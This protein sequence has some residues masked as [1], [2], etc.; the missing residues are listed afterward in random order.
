M[1]LCNYIKLLLQCDSK[2]SANQRKPAHFSPTNALG[3]VARAGGR[4]DH[5]KCIARFV[6]RQKEHGTKVPCSCALLVIPSP[7]SSRFGGIER[8][9]E[10]RWLARR[11]VR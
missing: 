2:T 11:G 9:R 10:G 4:G 8:A 6:Q 7:R 1:Q 5:C 3:G